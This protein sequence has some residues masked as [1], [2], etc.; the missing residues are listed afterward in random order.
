MI[1]KYDI[2]KDKSYPIGEKWSYRIEILDESYLEE[3]ELEIKKTTLFLQNEVLHID[4]I[5]NTFIK[6]E[7][8]KMEFDSLPEKLSSF[9]N[10]ITNLIKKYTLELNKE[11]Q[12]I[13]IHFTEDNFTKEQI[14]TLHKDE[15]YKKL[16]K[17]EKITINESIDKIDKSSYQKD[18]KNSLILL[19]CYPGY[20]RS[21]LCDEE[22]L[23]VHQHNISSNFLQDCFWDINFYM[24]IH[25]ITPDGIINLVCTGFAE[26][27]EKL[28]NTSLFNKIK[29]YYNVKEDI[30]YDYDFQIMGDYYLCKE[31]FYIKN[32]KI[33]ICELLN[34]ES[35]EFS[36]TFIINLV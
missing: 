21:G 31:N 5:G 9:F 16:S 2:L 32:A 35:I 14:D 30:Y 36:K 22:A 27:S 29:E 1:A 8:S 4:E 23:S 3:F 19:F 24:N 20:F 15:F 10:K 33:Q 28:L 13:D 26:D 6:V 17:K 11:G 25:N 12:I 7:F 34:E 18:I